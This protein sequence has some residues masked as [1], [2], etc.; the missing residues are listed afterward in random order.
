MRLAALLLVASVGLVATPGSAPD[1]A[2]TSAADADTPRAAKTVRAVIIFDKSQRNPFNSWIIWKAFRGK[3]LIE[4]QSWRAGSGFGG[5]NTQNPCVR[6]RGW[7]PN[8]HYDFVQHD[9]YWGQ[10]IKGRAFYLGNKACPNGTPRT[11][12]FIHTE[13]G[14]RNRQCRDGKGDQR[15]RWEWPKFNDY[16]SGGCIKMSPRDIRQL[17]HRYQRYFRAGVRYPARVHVKVRA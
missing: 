4:K 3:K 9:N 14:D 10:Y 8:G 15:C 12:L 2:A 11:E 7:L 17:T 1:A 5:P 13:T 16:R 6:G